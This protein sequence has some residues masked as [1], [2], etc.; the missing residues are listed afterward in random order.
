MTA[1]NNVARVSVV[2]MSP[3]AG[4]VDG[5]MHRAERYL[6][7]AAEE[8]AR[9]VVLPEL[10]DTGYVL[11]ERLAHL[12]S[13]RTGERVE[14]LRGLA[15]EHEITIA[16]ALAL[17]GEDGLLHDVGLV[18][19]PDG[20]LGSV[21][22]RYL[23][24]EESRFFEPGDPA[25]GGLVVSTPVGAVGMVVCYEIGFPEVCRESVLAGADLL[26][27]PS[28]FGRARLHAW[29]LL[30]R[31]RAL[32]NGVFLLAANAAGSN[33]HADFA[34]H[35]TIVDPHGNRRGQLHQGDGLLTTEADLS[36]I[37]NARAAIPYLT[38]LKRHSE[39]SAE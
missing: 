37:K 38:D 4:D 14:R 24:G 12:A 31:T 32:E 26:V 10:F 16:S 8:G 18:I 5:N 22:K 29:Q 23:W 25:A 35:S 27:V 28:A 34:A 6:A 9:L 19:T 20:A 33:G 2:Q 36:E 15:V 39:S 11:D 1:V 13:T 17:R 7:A 21:R 30:T 3:N